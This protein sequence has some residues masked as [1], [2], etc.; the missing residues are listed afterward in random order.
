MFNPRDDYRN[1]RLGKLRGLPGGIWVRNLKE[2]LKTSLEAVGQEGKLRLNN[3]RARPKQPR[4]Q[5][6][7]WSWGLSLYTNHHFTSNAKMLKGEP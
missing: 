2:E 3:T 6:L 7:V 1:S 5:G 4:A